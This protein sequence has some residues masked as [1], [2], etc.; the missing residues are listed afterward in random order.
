MNKNQKFGCNYNWSVYR[1]AYRKAKKKGIPFSPV[2]V[3]S[4]CDSAGFSKDVKEII[5]SFEEDYKQ[6][7]TDIGFMD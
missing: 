7:F 6:Y 1:K 2:G 4:A 3:V 5:L